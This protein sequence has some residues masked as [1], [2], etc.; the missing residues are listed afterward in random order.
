MRLGSLRRRYPEKYAL[1]R[2]WRDGGL[3]EQPEVPE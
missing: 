3:F 2:A 1:L